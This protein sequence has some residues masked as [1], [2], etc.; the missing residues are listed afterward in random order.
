M[1]LE[2]TWLRLR[3][4]GHGNDQPNQVAQKPFRE[5]WISL[6]TVIRNARVYAVAFNHVI[7]CHEITERL[8]VKK[9]LRSK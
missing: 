3:L 1:R 9:D 4:T 6:L 8:D 2:S 5:I 7:V